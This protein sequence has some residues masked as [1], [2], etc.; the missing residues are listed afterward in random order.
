DP[1]TFEDFLTTVTD[2]TFQEL[3]L[4]VLQ[5]SMDSETIG[6]H[7]NNLQWGIIRVNQLDYTLLT[8]D[9]PIV[10]SNG[11]IRPRSHIVMPISPERIF[12]ATDTPRTMQDVH[13]IFQNA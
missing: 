8:S 10:V 11:M 13:A 1:A 5:Q 9:R 12:V 6:N 7:I 2:T 3:T 4:R